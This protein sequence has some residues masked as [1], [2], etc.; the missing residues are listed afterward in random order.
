MPRLSRRRMVKALGASAFVLSSPTTAL[1]AICQPSR[2]LEAILGPAR[3]ERAKFLWS[4]PQWPHR[5]DEGLVDEANQ[6]RLAPAFRHALTAIINGSTSAVYDVDDENPDRGLELRREY[7][8][9]AL[10]SYFDL[11]PRDLA[12]GDDFDDAT[13]RIKSRCFVVGDA[14]QEFG[15]EEPWKY[16]SDDWQPDP[17]WMM[18]GKTHLDSPLVFKSLANKLGWEE[19][20]MVAAYEHALKDKRRYPGD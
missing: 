13:G 8:V 1:P 12:M 6:F 9:L 10:F 3:L 7:A 18:T 15:D 20:D 11:F 19:I 16:V 5:L 4:L 17:V 14:W 2:S